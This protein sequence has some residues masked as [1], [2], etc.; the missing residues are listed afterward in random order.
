MSTLTGPSGQFIFGQVNST[1][2][3]PL[4]RT[5]QGSFQ[6]PRYS[7]PGLW[8]LQ[9]TLWDSVSNRNHLPSAVLAGLGF[10]NSVTVSSDPAD[11]AGPTLED[12]EIVPGAIDVSLGGQTVTVR[13]HIKDDLAGAVF[14]PPPGFGL[15]YLLG[16]RAHQP[17]RQADPARLDRRDDPCQR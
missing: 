17:E 7:Q 5:F 2:G 4:E 15:P 9:V 14:L 12:V 6:F 10:P 16:H 1:A 3:T 11:T 13:Y 8:S